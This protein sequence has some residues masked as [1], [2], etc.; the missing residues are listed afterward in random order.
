M[1]GSWFIQCLCEE[2]K[3]YLREKDL[4]SIL[5]GVNMRMALEFESNVPDVPEMN[6]KKQIGSIV[7]TL[8]RLLYF[9]T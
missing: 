5:T 8:T 4:M 7:S 9:Y 3:Q 1:T 6:E 2:L